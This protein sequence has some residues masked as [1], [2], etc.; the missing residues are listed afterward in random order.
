METS[1]FIEMIELIQVERYRIALRFPAIQSASQSD[2]FD[3][4]AQDVDA[5]AG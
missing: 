4:T 3:I 1:L 5:A 2:H